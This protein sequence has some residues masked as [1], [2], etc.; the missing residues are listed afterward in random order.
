MQK[1]VIA[2]KKPDAASIVASHTVQKSRGE[3]TFALLLPCAGALSLAII[4]I[5]SDVPPPA[6]RLRSAAT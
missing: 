6:A 1:C 5:Y 3:R 4:S 2:G